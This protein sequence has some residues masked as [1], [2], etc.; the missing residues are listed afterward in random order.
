MCGRIRSW[1]GSRRQSAA[2]EHV[3]DG[4]TYG[5]ELL[6]VLGSLYREGALVVAAARPASDSNGGAPLA[7][8]HRLKRS[9]CFQDDPL[10]NAG[11]DTERPGNLEDTVTL[12]PE[13]PDRRLDG[14]LDPSPVE[15]RAVLTC[16]RQPGVHA[17]PIYASFKFRKYAQH[18]E[19]GLAR[20]GRGI[21]PLLTQKKINVLSWRPCRIPRRSVSDRPKRSTDPRLRPC[22]TSL[23]SA[24]VIV[25]RPGACSC[26]WLQKCRRPRRYG[27]V[28]AG[29]LRHR[30]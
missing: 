12:R 16:P 27:R 11:A 28:P 22:R 7:E 18:L 3:L 9:A 17:L 29:S 13:F 20:G 30:L 25:S 2:A 4:E 19:H 23:R 15:L 24:L 5:R 26:P 6:S 10:D 1:D 21:E 8:C 14:R